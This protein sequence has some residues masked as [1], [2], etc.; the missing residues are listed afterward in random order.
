MGIPARRPFLFKKSRFSHVAS[1]NFKQR[2]TGH[3]FVFFV[4][5]CK[6]FEQKVTKDTK[7]DKFIDVLAV[8]SQ[9]S[10]EVI[11]Q[12]DVCEIDEDGQD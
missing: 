12:Y 4:T 10:T 9:Y 8:F 5:F 1:Q 3:L 11:A 7:I 2:C 6:K